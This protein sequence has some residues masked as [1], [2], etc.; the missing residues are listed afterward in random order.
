MK[1]AEFDTLV[2]R[3]GGEFAT[4]GNWMAKC[5]AHDDSTPSLSLK[6]SNDGHEPK[7]LVHCL[8]GCSQARV[9]ESL[10]DYLPRVSVPSATTSPK[11]DRIEHTYYNWDGTIFGKVTRVYSYIDGER[12][13]SMYSQEYDNDLKRWATKEGGK[14]KGMSAKT[15]PLYGL[16]TIKGAPTHR[17]VFIVEGEGK[18]DLL[19]SLGLIAVC[20][21][22][23]A[24]KW[25]DH[26]CAPLVGRRII[27]CPDNDE[28]GH[29]HASMVA[30]SLRTHNI[31]DIRLLELP[32][33]AEKEDCVQF[34]ERYG[35]SE[36]N[37]LA[38]EA[39]EFPEMEGESDV[40]R[41][42][43]AVL[44]H[45]TGKAPVRRSDKASSGDYRKF[46]EN[47][48]PMRRDIFSGDGMYWDST[49]SLWLPILNRLATLK[50]LMRDMLAD[51]CPIKFKP[52]HIEDNLNH[53]INALPLELL[54]DIENWDGV[55]RIQ[56]MCDA[57]EFDPSTKMTSEMFGYFMKDWYKTAFQRTFNPE[58]Q[59]RMVVLQGTQ[60][61][62]KDFWVGVL[63]KALGQFCSAFQVSET[64]N[65]D[66]YM[67]LSNNMILQIGE[68]DK[69]GRMHVSIL[70]DIITSVNTQ[71]REAFGKKAMTRHSRA[72]FIS[73][74][75]VPD[76][77]RDSTGNRRYLVFFIK[78][79]KWN[80]PKDPADSAQVLAQAF[81]YYN[82]DHKFDAEL[83]KTSEATMKELID[84][85]TPENPEEIVVELYQQEVMRLAEEDTIANMIMSPQDRVLDAV[86]ES[87]VM[88]TIRDRTQYNEKAIRGIL[89]RRGYRKYAKVNGI[90]RRVF[91]MDPI[92]NTHHDTREASEK[93]S[94]VILR[95]LAM[96]DQVKVGGH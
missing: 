94:N 31:N 74:A 83:V 50:T 52:A 57:V 77:L 13:K 89:T 96:E 1:Q 3:L 38:K 5:P 47:A 33:L 41:E 64:N 54:V 26:L 73:T 58:V 45:E 27:I 2:S 39:P 91:L 95:R 21:Q 60:G 28:A 70:K 90:G 75:N 63:T 9:L 15:A 71:L 30:H 88:K 34:I 84:L 82:T 67:Q 22:G 43:A 19:C 56:T 65:K 55:D 11:K 62:G 86:Q 16:L 8:A 93:E 72:S 68:F 59:N 69:T 36:F 42:F 24:K 44:E 20:N 40:K 79:I 37:R 51:G 23:G 32:N 80:Y 10:R 4:N 6:L 61:A 76:I 66:M 18:V 78:H 14:S 48:I 87:I 35:H 53:H 49:M 29:M 85:L 7:L 17:S 12:V 92:T 81:H 25:Q 46:L